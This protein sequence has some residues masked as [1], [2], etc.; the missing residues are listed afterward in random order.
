VGQFAETRHGQT[1]AALPQ[2]LALRRD[3]LPA[4]L[5][6]QDRLPPLLGRDQIPKGA[7][8]RPIPAEVAAALRR[9]IPVEAVRR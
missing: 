4:G 3:R 1:S 7:P 5:R 6:L 8:R 2:H 9:P